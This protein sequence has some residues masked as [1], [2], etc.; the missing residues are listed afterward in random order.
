M[1]FIASSVLLWHIFGVRQGDQIINHYDA[2]GKCT[3]G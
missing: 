3:C 1:I 2:D